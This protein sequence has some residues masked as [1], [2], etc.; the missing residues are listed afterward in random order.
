[1]RDNYLFDRSSVVKSKTFF[2]DRDGEKCL[3]KHVLLVVERSSI[4]CI[5][6]NHKY[7]ACNDLSFI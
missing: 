1:M 4:C 7:L 2:S 3:M 6:Q 5:K